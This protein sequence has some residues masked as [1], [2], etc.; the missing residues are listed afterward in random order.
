MTSVLLDLLPV[1]PT[2]RTCTLADRRDGECV[3]PRDMGQPHPPVSADTSMRRFCCAP[4]ELGSPY[5][6]GHTWDA[7]SPSRR[8][9]PRP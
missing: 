6:P 1:S 2:A 5:C 8:H 9:G 4:V 3:W 7:T